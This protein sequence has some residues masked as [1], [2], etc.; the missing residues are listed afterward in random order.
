M[1]TEDTK[2][3]IYLPSAVYETLEQDVR[4]FEIYKKGSLTPN[5]NRFLN[6]L[7]QGYH[8]S[9]S[10]ESDHLHREIMEA[11]Q[12]LALSER[13]RQEIASGLINA[14][15]QPEGR[16]SGKDSRHISLKPTG[17]TK[18]IVQTID[19]Y[20]SQ[21]FRRL[22]TSYCQKTLSQ[23]ERYVFR[24][25]YAKLEQ[26]CQARQPVFF[27]TT[28][29]PDEIHEVVPFS[30]RTG[31]EEMFNYLLCQEE[32]KDTHRPEARAYALRR[33]QRVNTIRGKGILDA[34]VKRHLERMQTLGPQYAI[35]D[36]EEICVRLTDKG[37]ENYKRI[38]FG[39]P[40]Y[41]RMEERSDGFYQF[42]RCSKDQV[43]RYGR[44]FDPNTAE[45]L[46]P[47]SLRDRMAR[48]F[49]EGCAVYHR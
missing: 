37:L 44:R 45:I 25:N 38:Y 15:A 10:E 36:D 30:L 17:A 41:E 8:E 20:L 31:T 9:F 2:I 29:N 4:M 12:R 16:R 32:S 11:L 22:F 42:Y 27:S 43:Y 33:I 1:N 23:R 35:N 34:E 28:W 18:D 26:C 24:E 47:D 19:D 46:A 39:K 13:E 6:M 49:A 21:Y 14:V 5:M 40:K 3:N 7:V 48:F